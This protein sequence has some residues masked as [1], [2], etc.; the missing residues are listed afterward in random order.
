[1]T[2][3]RN[4]AFAEARPRQMPGVRPENS[5]ETE[6]TKRTAPAS[7][8]RYIGCSVIRVRRHVDRARWTQTADLCRR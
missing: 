3:I 6:F 4:F 7:E 2:P 1:L 8:Q 5:K